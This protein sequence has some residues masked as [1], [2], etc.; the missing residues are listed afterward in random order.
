MAKRITIPAIQL[1]IEPST[2]R[3]WLHGPNG[4]TILR[5]Q[6]EQVLEVIPNAVSRTPFADVRV[7]HDIHLLL[8]EE[9]SEHVH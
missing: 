4:A 5:I 8:P 2:G 1:E 7:N 6:T 9:L 3:M